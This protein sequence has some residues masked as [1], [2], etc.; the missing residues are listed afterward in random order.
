MFITNVIGYCLFI[1][2]SIWQA[3]S[4][5]SIS[6]RLD[7]L[8][9]HRAHQDPSTPFSYTAEIYNDS[10]SIVDT[11][12]E[13]KKIGSRCYKLSSPR[14]WMEYLEATHLC[15]GAYTV[16]RCDISQG[17]NRTKAHVWGLEFHLKRLRASF[18][19]LLKSDALADAPSSS[20]YE[21]GVAATKNIISALLDKIEK[22]K[23]LKDFTMCTTNETITGMVTILW[24][25]RGNDI[26]VQGHLFTDN[27]HSDPLKYECTPITAV[28]AGTDAHLP[29]RHDHIPSA[30]LS[31][32]CR[33]RRPLEDTFK[34]N[35]VG[36]VL[37]ARNI[38][39]S[40]VQNLELL[41]GLTSNLFIVYRDGTIRSPRKGVLR[42]FAQY[43]VMEAAESLGL[44][45]V[46]E[47][48][49]LQD[50]RDGLWV[51]SFVTS[52]VR[53]IIPV[54]RII[55]ENPVMPLD[56]TESALDRLDWDDRKWRVLYDYIVSSH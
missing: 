20:C 38:S 30:K 4:F 13:I 41:E 43:L 14:E 33:I 21:T 48:I 18:E 50:A 25:K 8:S 34:T 56:W 17:E 44:K 1:S 27:Q 28:I 29:S 24:S 47:P 32:W 6:K 40:P 36:E 54:G 10:I 42:G 2:L 51:E 12:N 7:V 39:S 53:L 35:G 11:T 23:Q 16:L 15:G 26:H 9:P 52:S 5:T 46:D 31:S 49:T 22:S 37:L 55:C 3:V 19:S 45:I